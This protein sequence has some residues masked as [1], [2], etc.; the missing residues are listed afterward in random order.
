MSSHTGG[1]PCEELKSL[2]P[3][4][5]AA[6]CGIPRTEEEVEV[7]DQR[8]FHTGSRVWMNAVL[9]S[10]PRSGNF[11]RWRSA[12]KARALLTRHISLAIPQRLV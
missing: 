11:E 10:R 5:V 1:R 8:P 2:P 4:P 6:L 12:A 9:P 7:S 3:R